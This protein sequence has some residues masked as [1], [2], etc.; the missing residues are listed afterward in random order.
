LAAKKGVRGR[1]LGS[2][3]EWKKLRSGQG[4][5]KRIEEINLRG[6]G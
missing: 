3:C 4:R 6:G 5:E 1:L 2:D